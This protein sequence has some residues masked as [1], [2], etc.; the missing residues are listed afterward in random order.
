V[1]SFRAFAAALLLC[2]SLLPASLAAAGPARGLGPL[3]D[4]RIADVQTVPNGYDDW[5]TTLVDWT[6]TVGPDYKPPDLV[7]IHKAGLTG[8]GL[9]RRVALA[10]LT[11]MATAA[12]RNGTPLGSFAA[13]RSYSQQKKLFNIYAKG[14]GYDNAITFSER[15]GHSEHQLGLTIDFMATGTNAMLSGDSATGRW[16]AANAWKYG[17]I[18]SYPKGKQSAVC[19]G[20]EPWHFRYFGRELAAKIHASGLTSREYLWSHFTLVDPTTGSPLPTA[21]V[22]PSASAIPTVGP[23]TSPSSSS[24]MPGGTSAA[25]ASPAVP[26]GQASAGTGPAAA[27]SGLDPPVLFASIGLVLAV[28]ALVVILGLVRR[29]TA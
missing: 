2:A 3:P 8:S 18:L 15:A 11:A 17:W 22:A 29:R 21:T 27:A 19:L 5:A 10:D 24:A 4:C 28:V 16:M 1:P 12:R 13:Y 25:V 7:D 23:I 6:L 9:I 26:A 20:Y 14:Y